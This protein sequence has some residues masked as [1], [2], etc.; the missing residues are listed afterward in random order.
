MKKKNGFTLIELLAIIVILAIIAVITVP[1]ILNVIANSK[2]GAAKDSAYG[3]KDAISKYYASASIE[4]SIKI[5]GAYSVSNGVLNGSTIDNVDILVSGTKPSSGYLIYSNNILQ[6]GCLVVDGYEVV[7]SNGNFDIVGKGNCQVDADFATDTWE[8]IKSNLRIDRHAYDEQIGDEKEIEIDGISYTVRLANTSSCPNGWPTTVSQTT[9]GVVIEFVDTIIDKGNNNTDG[10]LMG[11]SASNVGGWPVTT[12]RSFL[13]DTIFNKLPAELKADGMI[14]NTSVVSGHGSS[15]A[16]NFTTTDKLYLL[17][18]VE[19]WGKNV[20]L[21][22]ENVEADG[23]RLMEEGVTD[24]TRQL[25]YY[26]TTGSTR[27]K[28][29]TSGNNSSWWLRSALELNPCDYFYVNYSGDMSVS[30][31]NYSYY[32]VAPAFRIFD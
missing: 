13:N 3:Y 2:K 30:S 14:L 23:V 26:G 32:G 21:W 31:A 6:N 8:E 9:C 22:G 7:Y 29:N 5:N 19:I 1:I 16:N 11:P 20:D 27:V 28:T 12:M 10:H 25:Q 15:D 4:N 24:G 18:Y 17:S